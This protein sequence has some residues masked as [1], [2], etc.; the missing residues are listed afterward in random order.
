[1]PPE[2]ARII[3]FEHG[4]ARRRAGR[5]VEVPGGFAVLNDRYPGSYDD[6]RLIVRPPGPP[7]TPAAPPAGEV[8]RV[9]DEVLASRAHRYVCVDDDTLGAAYAPAFAAAG[10]THDVNLI[11]VFRGTPPVDPPAADHLTLEELLPVLRHDWRELLPDAGESVVEGLARRV[12]ERL[13]G[14]DVVQFRGVR[15]A[16]GRI[17]A[18]AD[19]YAHD[20]VAQIESVHTGTRHRGRGHARTLMTALLADAAGNDPIFLVAD[21]A[22]WPKDF[23]RRLGFE[24]LARTHSF[25]RT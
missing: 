25:L 18:R 11:M 24:P 2:L 9:A 23:Y 6:N 13:R 5:V 1:M 3:A 19:L 17:A 22:D 21:D 15:D 8:L 10:Y 16:D 14:A 20:G 12:A 4:F 7:G